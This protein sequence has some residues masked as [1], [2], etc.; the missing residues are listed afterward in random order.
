MRNRRRCWWNHRRHCSPEQHDGDGRLGAVSGEGGGWRV[1][2]FIR[3][4]PAFVQ[5]VL[6]GFIKGARRDYRRAHPVEFCTQRRQ[7][8]IVATGGH[9][10]GL[11]A[12]FG[13]WWRSL[14]RTA[15]RWRCR[16]ST[17]CNDRK[18]WTDGLATSF[19][20]Q[21]KEFGR[22]GHVSLQDHHRSAPSRP[23]SAQRVSTEAEAVRRL[24][25]LVLNRMTAAWPMPAK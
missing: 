4:V 2:D 1:L 5:G 18:A 25:Q 11:Q 17:Y 21:P 8:G 24:M 14:R 3:Y 22:N 9:S 20:L 12:P 15:V 23:I 16:R 10:G 6:L 13:R 19:R 7:R